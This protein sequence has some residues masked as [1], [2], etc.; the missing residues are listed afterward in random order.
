MN[1]S[2]SLTK[3]FVASVLFLI[4]NV[5]QGAL[6]AQGPIHEFLEQGPAGIIVGAHTHVGTL[7]WVTLA[8]AGALYYL[9]PKVSGKSLSWPGVVN[10]VF[11]IF[12]VMLPINSLIMILAGI[13]GGKA[14]I[15]G[16]SGPEIEAILTPFM[17]PVGILSIVCGIIFLI[18]SIQIIHTAT[19]KI[20]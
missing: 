16:K 7:G 14:F 18:F 11:W 8:L 6:Q 20:T 12:I 9:V 17:I 1:E 2:K 13:S 19:K 10:W 4:W 15:A 5:V 3:F